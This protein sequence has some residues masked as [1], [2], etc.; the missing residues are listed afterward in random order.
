MSEIETHPVQLP[1]VV[2]GKG[3]AP[4]TVTMAAYEVYVALYG[5]QE[6]MVTGGCRGGFHVNELV[7]FLYARGFPREEWRDRVNE[8]TEGMQI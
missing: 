2:S 3:R 8:A 6:A 1:R 7:T 5:K 4:K